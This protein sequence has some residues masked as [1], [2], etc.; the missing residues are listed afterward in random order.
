M[1]L[2]GSPNR[3]S[4]QGLKE[5]ANRKDTLLTGSYR[6][7]AKRFGAIALFNGSPV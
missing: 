2:N 6:K 5:Y 3:F 4:T 1:V 7:S